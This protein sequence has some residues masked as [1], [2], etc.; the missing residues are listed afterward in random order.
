MA[1][2]AP[3]VAVV[4]VG[5]LYPCEQPPARRAARQLAVAHGAQWYALQT[6]VGTCSEHPREAR[7]FG[8][9]KRMLDRTSPT[10]IVLD[11]AACPYCGVVQEPPPT[12]RKRCQACKQTIY[13]WTDQGS[14]RKHLVTEEEYTRV[15]QEAWDAEWESLSGRV[16]NGIDSGDWHQVKMAYFQQALMLFGEGHD[17]RLLAT[18]SRKAEL[19]YYL[20]SP[21]YQGMGVTKVQV[22]TVE[23]AACDEC[24]SLHGK[25]FDIDQALELMPIPVH[26]CRTRADKNV[27]GGWC[28]CSFIPVLPHRR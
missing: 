27:H 23:E 21:V 22:V 10:P 18:E 26:T 16:I 5:R 12:R 3:A 9:L 4:R 19:R 11:S 7:M 6:S 8:K 13:T 2:A 14:R 17:H 20:S 25:E 28:T 1:T 24:R 15:R